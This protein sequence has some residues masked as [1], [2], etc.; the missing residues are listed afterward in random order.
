MVSPTPVLS[1][2]T[3]LQH[4]LYVDG[5]FCPKHKRGSNK[6]VSLSWQQRGS[7]PKHMMW[8]GWG[9]DELGSM[10]SLSHP[11]VAHTKATPRKSWRKEKQQ[12]L[13]STFFRSLAF[14]WRSHQIRWHTQLH[15]LMSHGRFCHKWWS[16]FDVGN[17][18]PAPSQNQPINFTTTGKTA[19]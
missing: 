19:F 18:Y 7:M 9:M 13:C 5:I 2:E 17:L 6:F 14:Q 10:P 1:F 8:C 15:W 4:Q 12:Y 3:T 16:S 11:T